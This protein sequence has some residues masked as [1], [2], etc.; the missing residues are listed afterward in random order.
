[1]MLY[2][3]GRGV[4]TNFDLALRFACTRETSINGRRAT[5]EALW[6]ARAGAGLSTPSKSA[7]STDDG[8]LRSLRGPR[9]PHRRTQ[10]R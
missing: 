5:V 1:M 3:N 10:A 6:K 4:P 9:F 2:A 7:A 8:C